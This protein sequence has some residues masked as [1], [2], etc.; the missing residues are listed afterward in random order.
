MNMITRKALCAGLLL[1][2]AFAGSPALAAGKHHVIELTFESRWGKPMV[3]HFAPPAG[4]SAKSCKA[5]LPAAI[6]E[7]S[8]NLSK[9]FTKNYGVDMSQWSGAKFVKG[10]CRPFDFPPGQTLNL[11]LSGQ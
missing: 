10:D 11:K 5:S 6:A 8:P 3:L 9:P 4:F 7:Y 1:A 2:A